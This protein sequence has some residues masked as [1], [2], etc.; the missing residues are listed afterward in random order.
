VK[1]IFLDFE[2]YYDKDYS[3]RKM[4][5]VEYVLDPRFECNGVAVIEDGGPS[6]WIDGDKVQAFFD[7]IDPTVTR[8]VTFNALFDMCIC[9]WRFGWV[10]KQMVCT[11]S[12]A[13]ACI[14]HLLKRGASLKEVLRVL[15]L[16]AKGDT[17][18][19]VIGMNLAAIKAAGLYNEYTDYAN[20][21]N[22][23]NVGIFNKLV[24]SNIFPTGELEVMDMVLR[25]A[26]NPKFVLDQH[27]LAEYLARTRANKE[28]LIAACGADRSELMSNEKF[29]AKLRELGVDPPTKLSLTT[30]QETYAFAK[31][32]QGMADLEEHPDPN[33]QALAAARL[34]VKTT[35]EE[36]RTERFLK[37]AQLRWPRNQQGNM[38]IPLRFSGAHTHR[39]SGDWRLNLQNLPRGGELRRALLAPPGYVVVAP[40][41]SQIEARLVAWFAGQ[42]DLV[43]QFSKGEDVYSSFAS[44]VFEKECSK[45]TPVERFIGKTA[46]LGMGYG[47]GG[48]KF[49]NTVK[50][51]SRLQL[52]KEVPLPDEE[53]HKIVRAYR[54]KYSKIPGCWRWLENK[55][56]PVLAC[57]GDDNFGTT[58]LRSPIEDGLECGPIQFYKGS[59]RLPSGLRLFYQELERTGGGWIYTYAGR[60]KKL[61]G[62][63]LLENIIQALA[64]IIVMDAG[65]R[66]QRRVARWGLELASQV[67]DELVYVV[68]E[69]IAAPFKKLVLEEMTRRPEWAPNLPLAAEAGV[70][71]SYGEAK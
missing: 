18:P 45:K 38:P 63:A 43:A 71:S 11:M 64:R 4:T 55:A 60:Q 49:Q 15:E 27:R 33:V 25:C 52:G 37:I 26:I 6:Y 28:A 40:D 57:G 59:I 35:L 69:S 66:I 39:L 41:A 14:G 17:L 19:K 56:I 2:T 12:V 46:I 20:N 53:A 23:G 30:G 9:A 32:D 54:N 13:R 62:G 44:Y 31:T 16:P 48:E 1:T 36:T 8:A 3:L 61:Y 47:V 42:E 70:G 21:D 7:R 34:G 65:V 51:L 24:V 22:E 29:A 50:V 10:P 67:H 68:P 58:R 5:P